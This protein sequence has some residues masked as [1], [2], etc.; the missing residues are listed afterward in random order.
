MIC[1]SSPLKSTIPIILGGYAL[2]SVGF[3]I[4]YYYGNKETAFASIGDGLTDGEADNFYTSVQKFNTTLGRQIG[5]P[6]V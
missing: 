4:W 6:I 5:T 2:K 1:T 3:P